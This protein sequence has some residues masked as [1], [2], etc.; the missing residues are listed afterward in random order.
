MRLPEDGQEDP[1]M[2]EIRP[3]FLKQEIFPPCFMIVNPFD[4]TP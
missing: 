4:S 1:K 3:L 2:F